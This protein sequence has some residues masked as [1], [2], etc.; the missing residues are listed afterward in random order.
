M[1]FTHSRYLCFLVESEH[2]SFYESDLGGWIKTG[3]ITKYCIYEA[4]LSI[5]QTQAYV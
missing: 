2:G 5:K 4:L 1:L 3:Q